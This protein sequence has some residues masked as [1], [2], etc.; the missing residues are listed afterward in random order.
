MCLGVPTTLSPFSVHLSEACILSPVHPKGQ[1][2][3]YFIKTAS[4]RHCKIGVEC[5]FTQLLDECRDRGE[6]E[7]EPVIHSL[8]FR[9]H[10][11]AGPVF[12]TAQCNFVLVVG[13]LVTWAGDVGG[14]FEVAGSA[15]KRAGVC[16]DGC[17]VANGDEEGR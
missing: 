12:N 7:I 4:V 15:Y 1:Q 10:V 6:D 11:A 9:G 3:G 5:D 13:A 2:A 8:F 14:A 17:T 16:L